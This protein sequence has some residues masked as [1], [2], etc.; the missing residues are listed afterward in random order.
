MPPPTATGE[1]GDGSPEVARKL[2]RSLKG[3]PTKADTASH[4]CFW[5]PASGHVELLHRNCA[6]LHK[7]LLV[8]S[9]AAFVRFHGFGL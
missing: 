7:S 3:L 4:R 2:L 5:W 6:G 8:Y 9:Y 1:T